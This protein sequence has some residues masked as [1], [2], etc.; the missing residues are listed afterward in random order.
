MKASFEWTH[1]TVKATWFMPYMALNLFNFSKPFKPKRRIRSFFFLLSIFFFYFQSVTYVC[2]AVSLTTCVMF[3]PCF[4]LMIDCQLSIILYIVK[5]L[6]IVL[7]YIVNYFVIKNMWWE[8]SVRN[9]DKR[10]GYVAWHWICATFPPKKTKKWVTFFELSI[11]MCFIYVS[12]YL[13][14]VL[15]V[16]LLHSFDSYRLF[17]RQ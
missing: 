14:S 13:I 16:M 17:A 3:Y 5:S 11:Y 1:G 9:I 15:K 2:V 6:S 7:R 12:E 10:W 4:I 8:K